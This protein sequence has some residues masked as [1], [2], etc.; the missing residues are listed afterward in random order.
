MLHPGGRG[1]LL[2][3]DLPR[4]G[5]PYSLYAIVSGTKVLL[6]QVR[7]TGDALAF[8]LPPGV[9]T[10]VLEDASGATIAS[11]LLAGREIVPPEETDASSPPSSTPSTPTTA[12]I[13]GGVPLPTL[14]PVPQ[15]PIE[16]PTTPDGGIDIRIEIRALALPFFGP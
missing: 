15:P 11:N 3:V 4:L 1:Y 7:S 6:G 10:L 16:L 5:G 9:E 8:R 12:G 2:A 14:P 13:R